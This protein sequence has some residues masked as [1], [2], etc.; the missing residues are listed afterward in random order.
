MSFKIN[1]NN[2]DNNNVFIQFKIIKQIWL[3][4]ALSL[5]Y[6]RK[7]TDQR[8]LKL[9]C[10]VNILRSVELVD[11]AIWRQALWALPEISRLLLICI[12]VH[13][14]RTKH[15][16][17]FSLHVTESHKN[18]VQSFQHIHFRNMTSVFWSAFFIK[19]HSLTYATAL[20]RVRLV[21][22]TS[23]TRLW[24]VATRGSV[25]IWRSSPPPP[26]L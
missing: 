21:I 24:R 20:E 8:N 1:S 16:S 11:H 23:F 25:T 4:P 6:L 5:R 17:W 18:V 12:R 7:L 2:I 26:R 10:N 14:A 3:E 15:V 19:T 22:M 9:L 13:I